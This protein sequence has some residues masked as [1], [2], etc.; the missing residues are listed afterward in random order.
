MKFYSRGRVVGKARLWGVVGHNAEEQVENIKVSMQPRTILADLHHLNLLN[1]CPI[2]NPSK[3]G[4]QPGGR[5][6]RA[7]NGCTGRTSFRKLVVRQQ[8]SDMTL[9]LSDL[10]G[11]RY[12]AETIS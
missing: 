4:L 9:L 11:F 1:H 5:L 8:S 10:E 12:R 6:P 2:G 3:R 7:S